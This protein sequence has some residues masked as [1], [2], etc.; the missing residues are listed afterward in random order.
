MRDLEKDIM[1][2]PKYNPGTGA[3]WCK[4][5]NKKKMTSSRTDGRLKGIACQA[6]QF[7]RFCSK[8]SRAYKHTGYAEWME[9]TWCNKGDRNAYYKNI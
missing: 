1:I 8:S 4:K 5:R 7:D 6:S 3:Y 9:K 2:L